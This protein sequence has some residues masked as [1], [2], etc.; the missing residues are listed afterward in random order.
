MRL[1]LNRRGKD[2]VLRLAQGSK[3][4]YG[5][6]RTLELPIKFTKDGDRYLLYIDAK[7]SE[8]YVKKKCIKAFVPYIKDSYEEKVLDLC[9]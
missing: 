5:L 1:L 9:L 7:L 2:I 8:I 4:R 6:Y 3:L